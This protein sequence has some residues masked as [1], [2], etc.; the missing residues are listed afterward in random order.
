[1]DL[2]NIPV[3]IEFR[4]R[5]NTVHCYVHS[6]FVYSL[7]IDYLLKIQHWATGATV[8]LGT[9]GAL[10]GAEKKMKK[11]IKDSGPRL[12]DKMEICL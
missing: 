2:Q 1:M 3:T 9:P 10:S 7:L 5:E 12:A 6:L 8:H 11:C 4:E